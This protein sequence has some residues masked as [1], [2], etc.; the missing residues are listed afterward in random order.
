MMGMFLHHQSQ[1][2]SDIGQIAIDTRPLRYRHIGYL[3]DSGRARGQYSSS[4]WLKPALLRGSAGKAIGAPR[5]ML[6]K[7][8]SVVAGS[9]T[10]GSGA[11]KPRSIKRINNDAL[12]RSA[13]LEVAEPGTSMLVLI[14][15]FYAL[16]HPCQGGW[17]ESWKQRITVPASS[18]PDMAWKRQPKM[19][20]WRVKSAWLQ[21]VDPVTA[22]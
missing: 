15:A 2:H 9:G 12:Q 1:P 20:R 5:L 16:M 22:R 14:F 18:C 8:G 11:F 13:R 6:G 10:E 21:E 3:P 19:Q 4:H 7:A 17:N